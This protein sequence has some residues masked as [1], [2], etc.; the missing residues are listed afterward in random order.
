MARQKSSSG[1]R[2][3]EYRDRPTRT[4]DAGKPQHLGDELAPGLYVTAN[5]YRP[6]NKEGKKLPAIVYVCGHSSVVENGVSMGSKTGYQHHGG[7][8]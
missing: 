6:H 3:G 1:S 5:L 2:R 8:C 4:P 7:L